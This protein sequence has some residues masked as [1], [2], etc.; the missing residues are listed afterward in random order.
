MANDKMSALECAAIMK[1]RRE[2]YAAVSKACQPVFEKFIGPR[3][4]G[5]YANSIAALAQ[6]EFMRI[7]DD[8]AK[9]KLIDRLDYLAELLEE[10]TGE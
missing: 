1:Y 10:R 9:A 5:T 6:T 8:A 3:D 7:I 4:S 2:F